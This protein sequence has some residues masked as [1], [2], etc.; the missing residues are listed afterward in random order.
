MW[1]VRYCPACLENKQN[2]Y[3]CRYIIVVLL[4]FCLENKQNFYYCR[5]DVCESDAHTFREQTKFLLL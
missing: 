2:F 3:Y 4:N 1:V 5:S